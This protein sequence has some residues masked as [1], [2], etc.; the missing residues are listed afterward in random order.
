MNSKPGPLGPDLY[1]YKY[2]YMAWSDKNWRA[3]FTGPRFAKYL[4]SEIRSRFHRAFAEMEP[5]LLNL[6][7]CLS[8]ACPVKPFFTFI[9]GAANLTGM[10][11]FDQPD[12]V[13]QTQP[14]KIKLLSERI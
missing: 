1:S 7:L 4:S 3:N 13:W 11:H 8:G 12:Y 14:E 10:S 5:V 6:F 9:W 2:G